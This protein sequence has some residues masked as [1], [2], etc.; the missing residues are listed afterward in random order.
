MRMMSTQNGSPMVM[1]PVWRAWSPPA[2]RRT[3]AST[4]S[5]TPQK[6]RVAVG[7]EGFP[8][9][10]MMSA[11]RDAESDEVTKKS[12]TQRVPTRAVSQTRG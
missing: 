3:A 9:E 8:P 10:A 1:A 2:M 7:G 11:T 12:T 4:P 6:I 5:R